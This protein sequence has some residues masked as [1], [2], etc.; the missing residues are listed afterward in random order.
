MNRHV[1]RIL[2]VLSIA[3]GVFA[4]PDNN[5]A[6]AGSA[7]PHYRGGVTYDGAF[8]NPALV[9]IN[10][11][12][13]TSLMIMPTGVAFW[14]DKLLPIVGPELLLDPLDIN[15]SLAR[16][17]TACFE[18]SFGVNEYMTPE[19]V[20]EILTKELR[21]GLNI[22]A[23]VNS[24]PIAFS[25][26]GFGFN[27][28]SYADVEMHIPDA[29]LLPIFSDTDGLLA[30]NMFDLSDLHLNAIW[31]SEVAINLGAT[32][33]VPVIRDYLRL[34]RAAAGVGLKLVLGHGYFSAEAEKGST[35]GYDSTTNLYKA[36]AK[37]DVINIG[38][39]LHGNFRFDN[40]LLLGKPISGQGWGL[41]LGTVFHNDNH[42][43]SID[44][45]DIG[46]I[47]W[48]GK[49]IHRGTLIF[50]QEFQP[51]DLIDE[52]EEL[53]DL[54]SLVPANKSMVTWLPATLNLG[55]TY[56]HSLA[57]SGA[58]EVFLGYVSASA[59]YR[60][61]LVLG[62]GQNTY[63][64]RFSVGATAGLLAG[65]LPVR[66]GIFLGGQEGIS[67]SL[68]VGFDM[69]YMSIDA[70]YKAI[71]TPTL[72]S[73]HG[74]ALAAGLTFRWGWK[75]QRKFV[76]EEEQIIIEE[77]V[78]VEEA[79]EEDPPLPELGD[80]EEIEVEEVEEVEP[81]VEIVLTME[82]PTQEE[83]A[84][85]SASQHAIN[86]RS[87]GAELTSGS[88]MA[89]NEIA[90]YLKKYPR[91]R[92]EIQGHTDSQGGDMFNMLLSAER[93]ATV[94]NY[95]VSQGVSEDNLIAIG[96]GKNMPIADNNTVQGR[97]QNRRVQFVQIISD[98]EFER[99][100][101]LEV[102]MAKNMTRRVLG[103]SR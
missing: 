34:D 43:V 48:D 84:L 27:I 80:F 41:D 15:R 86:F 54:D 16:Y 29:F 42:L 20:S 100:R 94:K 77:P 70:S 31:A 96:Y 53:F 52:L 14:S 6:G 39:G 50:D 57:G 67:S 76:A 58:A 10:R 25:T 60:Q 36:D 87:G 81:F 2:L 17:L 98:E 32:I 89:L 7:T 102:E 37:I 82:Q 93:A 59:T 75:P 63:M 90:E 61:Q 18:N 71:G 68:G 46:M 11:P 1:I 22:Y 38:T 26:R 49:Q 62:I 9:G 45:R 5:P 88:F 101:Q 91:I 65:Y 55:Y 13:R 72:T 95:L 92:Y 47:F 51:I 19:R 56:H 33:S 44:V 23:G 78:V 69:K 103:G 85:F 73:K 99:L 79:P 83:E 74:F 21:G 3:G 64:P 12:P 66:Y 28:R 97:A 24:S 8:G 30:G 40:A 4:R 35:I